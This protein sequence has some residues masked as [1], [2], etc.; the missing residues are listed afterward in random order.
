MKIVFERFWKNSPIS[1]S[2]KIR[3]V[4]A[5]LLHE[6]GLTDKQTGKGTWWI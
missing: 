1:S 3:P 5:N 4:A 6:E 2:M